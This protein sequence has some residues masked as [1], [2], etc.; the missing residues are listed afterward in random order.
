MEEINQLRQQLTDLR[1]ENRI[2]KDLLKR[3]H[4][5]FEEYTDDNSYR[6]PE[7]FAP[8]QG[9]RIV[10]PQ[11]ITEKIANHFYARFWGRQDVFALRYE[12][13]NTGKSGYVP[14]C[15]NRWN[16]AICPKQ[17]KKKQKCQECIHKDYVR[18]EIGHILAHLRG[19]KHNASDVVGVYPLL[20]NDMCRFLV[21]DFDNHSMEASGKDFANE[22]DEWREEVDGMRQI[23]EKNGIMPLV[24]RS[25]SGKGAHLWIFFQEPIPAVLARRFGT[26]L[27]SSLELLL[28][29][30]AR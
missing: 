21:F 15:H 28:G 23:C 12:S 2:L 19:R 18:L 11:E 16:D 10:H 29:S 1:E 20:P 3:N 14:Q 30:I 27:T 13:K 25:R 24:E 4:I 26:F 6:E 22:D 9:K 7:Q 17:Q 8:N 5:S